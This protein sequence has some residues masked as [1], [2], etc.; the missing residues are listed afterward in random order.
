MLWLLSHCHCPCQCHDRC[1][2]C[3]WCCRCC[4]WPDGP[5]QDTCVDERSLS[6]ISGAQWSCSAYQDHSGSGCSVI[7]IQ[8]N[9]LRTARGQQNL[10]LVQHDIRVHSHMW[11]RNSIS[12]ITNRQIA[13]S[14]VHL[15]H[16]INH[17]STT[18]VNLE[19]LF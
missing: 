6:S 9:L 11:Q 10:L 8:I 17:Y 7:R 4:C 5:A 14:T 19:T 15:I 1:H 13:H 18:E 16:P 3:C 12:N 2:C